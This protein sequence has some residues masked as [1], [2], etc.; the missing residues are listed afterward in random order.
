MIILRQKE[1]G[2]LGNIFKRFTED[3]LEK[4]YYVP[5]SDRDTWDYVGR[6][7]MYKDRD[8]ERVISKDKKIE[9]LKKDIEYLEHHNSINKRTMD[10]EKR[11]YDYDKAKMWFNRNNKEIQEKKELLKKLES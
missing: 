6:Q 1:F 8:Y 10:I 3:S 7:S 9:H 5:G 2:M 4:K 11:G